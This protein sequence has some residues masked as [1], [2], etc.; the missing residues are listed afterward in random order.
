MT[1]KE[2]KKKRDWTFV[3]TIMKNV[4]LNA[5]TTI[6]YAAR[7]FKF[8]GDTQT[9]NMS[10]G[11]TN[12]YSIINKTYDLWLE[13]YEHRDSLQKNV[14]HAINIMF[15]VAHNDHV[16]EEL[17]KML[18]ENIGEDYIIRKAGDV[19]KVNELIDKTKG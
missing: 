15:T 18:Y 17:A 13:K 19:N 1:E 9:N 2:D 10:S 3:H 16:Y 5:I 8:V 6:S 4:V 7:T 14:R 11:L 12:M